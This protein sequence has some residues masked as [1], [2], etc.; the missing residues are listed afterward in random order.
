MLGLYL[1]INTKY[2]I[3]AG[4][5]IVGYPYRTGCKVVYPLKREF[6]RKSTGYGSHYKT[7]E[8]RKV[9]VC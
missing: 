2:P 4:K 5:I 8:L 9:R 1:D 7:I 3:Q 6:V